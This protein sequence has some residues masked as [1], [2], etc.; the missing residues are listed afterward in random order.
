MTSTVTTYILSILSYVERDFVSVALLWLKFSWNS[1][2]IVRLCA[3]GALDQNDK[4]RH[5]Q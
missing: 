3:L 1:E 2:L 5:I 4:K